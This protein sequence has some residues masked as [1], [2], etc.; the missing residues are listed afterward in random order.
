MLKWLLVVAAACVVAMDVQDGGD[1]TRLQDMVDRTPP[2]VDVSQ[3]IDA[4]PPFPRPL[5]VAAPCTGIHGC[6]EAMSIMKAPIVTNNAFDLQGGYYSCLLQQLLEHGMQRVDI[7][8]ALRLGK[9]AGDLMKVALDALDLPVDILICGPPCPPWAGQ[10]NH[11]NLKDPRAK[12][13]MRILN[14]VVVLAHCG[15]LLCVVI[16]N[17][18]GILASYNGCESAADRFIRA[19][20][21]AVPFFSWAVE[22]LHLVEYARPQ[23][24]VRTF[25]RGLRK[26]IAAVIPRSLP[27]FGRCDL[28]DVLGKFPHTPRASFSPQQQEN[29]MT[30]E[31]KIRRWVE[32][33]HLKHGDIVAIAPDRREGLDLTF[34]QSITVNNSPTLTTGNADV[35]F[36]S[37]SDVVNEVPDE[38]RTFFRKAMPTERLTLQGF[39]AQLVILLGQK[40][41]EFASGNA[42]PPPLIVATLYPLLRAIADSN[43]D[44]AKWP[45]AGLPPMPPPDLMKKFQSLLTARPRIINK[46]KHFNL[47]KKRRRASSSEE[48]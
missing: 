29:I 11:K 15:G 32:M 23:T 25:I 33:G 41:A 14:W 35:M 19:L 5:R 31:K 9:V 3:F 18:K 37:V 4:L 34:S 45:P 40:L 46:G 30:Y 22:T 17:V 20:E 1:R 47:N 39:R 6:G 42:Y 28:K 44:L 21:F 12:V 16:E 24:R 27:A 2:L 13:F 8:K 36:L 10:G 48:E 38:Q 26:T 7:D 43:L